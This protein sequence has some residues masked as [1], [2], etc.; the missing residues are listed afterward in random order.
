MVLDEGPGLEPDEGERVFQRFYRGLGQPAAAR[1]APAS[2]SR[3]WSR[4]PRAG[5]ARSRSRT[6]PRAAPAP[7]S[8]SRPCA[9][10]QELTLPLT[11]PCRGGARVG[12]DDLQTLR[13]RR[14]PRHRRPRRRGG[15]RPAREQHLRRQRGP[16]RRAA[17]RGRDARAGGAPARTTGTAATDAR[18][19][20]RNRNRG[21]DDTAHD[22]PPT[23]KRPRRPPRP[24]T[25]T[26]ASSSGDSGQRPR[27][28]PQLRLGLGLQ[29]LGLR[30]LDD[31]P[32][33]EDD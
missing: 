24:T 7:R 3:W 8:R 25:T 27:T 18:N 5:A 22:A 12:C 9:L 26:A 16:R 2:A 4:S 32:E 19:R 11:S 6:G 20:N 30:R 14:R 1:P 28:G 29:R 31:S 15:D 17:E 21:G 10:C 23:P 13:N 33:F